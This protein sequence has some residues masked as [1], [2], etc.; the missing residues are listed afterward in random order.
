MKEYD[1]YV[2]IELHS[3]NEAKIAVVEN[4]YNCTEERIDELVSNLI[5]NLEN[6]GFKVETATILNITPIF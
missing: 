1:W 2:R 4:V 6:S 3:Y 5:Q